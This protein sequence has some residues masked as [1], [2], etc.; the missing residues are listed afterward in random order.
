MK[1]KRSLMSIAMASIMLIS[2]CAVVST[3]SV[4]A[5]TSSSRASVKATPD[6]VGA[7]IAAGTGPAACVLNNSSSM[8]IFVKGYDGA[9]WY[10]IWDTSM[11]YWTGGWTSLGG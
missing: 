10:R 1:H 4:S 11:D 8:Y 6:L 7:P 2:L 9:C 3:T 5:A